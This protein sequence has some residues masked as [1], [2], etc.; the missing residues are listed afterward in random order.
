MH[1]DVF[2]GD[3]DGICALLQLRLADPKPDAVLVTGVKR[4]ISLVQQIPVD[5]AST[6]M[7]LDVS[8]EKNRA[9]VDA[10]LAKGC[11]ITYIDH[12]HMGDEPLSHPQFV[13]H[14]DT[15]PTTCTS[16]IVNDLLQ[17]QFINWAI[18]A[19]FGDN[20]MQIARTM[21]KEAGL[22]DI[23]TEQLEAIGTCINYNGY[24]ATEDDL[25]VRPAELFTA[26]KE[27][28]DPLRL[29]TDQ[30]PIWMTL[31]EGY[32]ADMDN[33]ANSKVIHEDVGLLVIAL[34]DEAWARRVSGVVGNQLANDHPNRAIG[35]LTELPDQSTDLLVSI[36]APL[37]NRQGADVVARQFET[38][39]GRSAA[40]GINR[41]PANRVTDFIA[42]MKAQ[43]Q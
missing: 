12:H 32:A 17:G 16:L 26:F 8:L 35:V 31:A 10:L 22:T 15:Q 20:L 1:Y 38:G 40:A 14:V 21:A 36:R 41:L 9:A 4:D 24:G 34:P 33:A 5:E 18:A 23:E 6:V 42:V 39:G 13:S 27:Y 19:A 11:H 30:H 3:A 25:H 28:P 7:V 29:I 43:W 37:N 2:N